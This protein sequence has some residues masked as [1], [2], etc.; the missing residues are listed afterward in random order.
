MSLDGDTI[1]GPVPKLFAED[2]DA[3]REALAGNMAKLQGDMAKLYMC[4]NS[5]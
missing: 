3:S 5:Q 1:A 2:V 4:A